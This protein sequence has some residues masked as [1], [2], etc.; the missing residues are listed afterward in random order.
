MPDSH[1]AK[2]GQHTGLSAGRAS[3]QLH[4]EASSSATRGITSLATRSPPQRWFS[5]QSPAPKGVKPSSEPSPS[6]TVAASSQRPGQNTSGLSCRLPRHVA[7]RNAARK[8]PL[9]MATRSPPPP[10]SAAAAR[11]PSEAKADSGMSTVAAPKTSCTPLKYRSVSCARARAAA[12]GAPPCSCCSAMAASRR[13]ASLSRGIACSA[14]ASW[15]RQRANAYP[16]LK[17]WY[18]SASSAVSGRRVGPSSRRYDASSEVGSPSS[19]ASAPAARAWLSARAMKPKIR[20]CPSRAAPPAAPKRSDRA[21]SSN[22]EKFA[23]SARPNCTA[24]PR[25]TGRPKKASQVRCATSV[26]ASS[27][28]ATGSPPRTRSATPRSS[29]RTT[30]RTASRTSPGRIA[31][32]KTCLRARCSA[33]SRGGRPY[34]TAASAAPRPP[35]GQQ[36]PRVEAGGGGSL[37]VPQTVWTRPRGVRGHFVGSRSQ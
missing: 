19:A 28:R 21:M 24:S 10:P 14:Y 4:A 37:A 22:V 1:L 35:A 6:D 8:S 13:R 2:S 33:P 18:R 31:A 36:P 11:A 32:W 9:G 15:G 17:T 26:K 5:T 12:P 34:S 27:A 30:A 16:P 25:Q 3:C 23:S 29:R 20:S 7:Y